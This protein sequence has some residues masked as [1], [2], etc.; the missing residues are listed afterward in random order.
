MDTSKLAK[1][2]PRCKT[3][4]EPKRHAT[5]VDHTIAAVCGAGGAMLGFSIGGPAGAAAG[6][7][8]LYALGKKSMLDLSDRH[9][10]SQWFKYKCPKCGCTWK[11]RIH[12]ND[13]PED[14]NW[15]SNI[16]P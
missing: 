2:C 11:E 1:E 9:A 13:D 5:G 3:L 6:A 4:I 16:G 7:A 10:H 12:T 15:L 14:P 8:A